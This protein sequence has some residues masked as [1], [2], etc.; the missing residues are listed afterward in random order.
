M[1][2]LAAGAG[3]TT[4]S[5]YHHFD[6]KLGLYNV[7]HEEAERRLL[8]R[9]QGAASARAGDGVPAAVRGALVVGFDFATE[10]GFVRLL[11]DAHPAR[12]VD[13]VA[14][15]LDEV[16]HGG[17][18]PVGR[19]LAAAWRAALMAVAGGTP[20]PRARAALELLSVDEDALSRGTRAEV[21]R[22]ER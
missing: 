11:G 5:L 4:G 2:E 19:V 20:P 22:S 16:C 21:S 17:Q 13:P 12:D 6:N 14:D 15:L 1:G 10:Q 8:D 18:V 7:V 3:V 9:M